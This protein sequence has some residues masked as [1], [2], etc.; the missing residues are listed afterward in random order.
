MY[1][2][3]YYLTMMRSKRYIKRTYGTDFWRQFE[4]DCGAVFGQV[5]EE[6]PDIGDSIFSFNYAYAP[7]YVAWYTVMRMLGLDRREADDLITAPVNIHA[8]PG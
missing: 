3:I 6:L 7:S 2:F 1:R 8:V 5:A 4:R